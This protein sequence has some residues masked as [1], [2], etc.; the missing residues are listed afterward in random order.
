MLTSSLR[1]VMSVTSNQVPLRTAKNLKWR[2]PLCLSVTLR[3]YRP[4]IS[5]MHC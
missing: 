3:F 2:G 5:A 1:V 4:L